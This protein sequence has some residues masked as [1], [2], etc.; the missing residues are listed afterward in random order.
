LCTITQTVNIDHAPEARPAPLPV[1]WKHRRRAWLKWNAAQPDPMPICRGCGLPFDR[2]DADPI[3]RR[4]CTSCGVGR[5]EKAVRRLF[6]AK[7]RKARKRAL[8]RLMSIA[9]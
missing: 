4:Y 6:K 3:D 2:R 9:K 5:M 7:G 1:P 8:R